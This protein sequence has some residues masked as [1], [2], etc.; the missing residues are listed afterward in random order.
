MSP[1]LLQIV[2]MGCCGLEAQSGSCECCEGGGDMAN[3]W[4]QREVGATFRI[5]LQFPP[6]LRPPVPWK[7]L[8]QFQAPTDHRSTS[9]FPFA[10][11]SPLPFM[12][13]SPEKWTNRGRALRPVVGATD[14]NC[15][16]KSGYG[17]ISPATT[18]P[19]SGLQEDSG[20]DHTPYLPVMGFGLSP[21]GVTLSQRYYHGWQPVPQP[22]WGLCK[23]M[24]ELLL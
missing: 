11:N 10:L 22:Q 9:T 2:G 20:K 14:G 12:V 15:D 1:T 3:H 17:A 18:S 7:A 4:G 16:G 6:F 21:R 24:Q 8:V 5:F 13:K 19:S 23:P